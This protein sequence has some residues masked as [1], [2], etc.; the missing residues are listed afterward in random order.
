MPDGG[1]IPLWRKAFHSDFGPI[2]QGRE[3][4]EF[5]AWLDLCCSAVQKP[6]G[7]FVKMPGKL[8]Y[9]LEP[10][11]LLTT[12]RGLQQRWKWGSH[13]KVRRFIHAL[14]ILK[15]IE[16]LDQNPAHLKIVNAELYGLV[17]TT[18]R[19][20]DGPTTDQE[21]TSDGP[22]QQVNKET[23]KQVNNKTTAHPD[24]S[25][26]EEFWT[27]YPKKVDM[28]QTRQNWR[29]RIR[30]GVAAEDMI[31]AAKYFAEYRRTE[32]PHYTTKPSNFIG[33]KAEWKSWVKGI[34]NDMKIPVQ[35]SFIEY[36]AKVEA[37]R[38]ADKANAAR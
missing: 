5:E 37:L 34:P 17:R 21:R 12:Y 26:F 36:E 31:T 2:G 8:P 35:E 23:S 15:S 27:A 10:G 18:E 9:R 4:T 7:D 22:V 13:N 24:D 6:E 20:S 16:I 14:C 38:Q 19:N 29:S 25:K 28:D 33:R 32:D 1:W 11:E 3:Y 30:E